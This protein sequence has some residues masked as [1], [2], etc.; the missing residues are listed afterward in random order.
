MTR[1]KAKRDDAPDVNEPA[2]AA[3]VTTRHVGPEGDVLIMEG[4]AEID[5]NDPR[6]Q[7][8]IQALARL[9]ADSVLEDAGFK[10]K[11][12]GT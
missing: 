12:R 3:T 11:K 6:L 5:P 1:R 4:P 7:P 10:S 9:I 8:F 2:K